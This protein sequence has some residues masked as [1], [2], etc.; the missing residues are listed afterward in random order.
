MS[1]LYFI[2]LVGKGVSYC[3]ICDGSDFGVI[4]AYVLDWGEIVEEEAFDVNISCVDV[5]D[6]MYAEEAEDVVAEG[7]MVV[8]ATLPR[9]T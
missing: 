5:S 2:M 6:V 1:G 4:V 3:F 7:R 9:L 8:L